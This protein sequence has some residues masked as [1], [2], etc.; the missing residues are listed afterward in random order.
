MRKTL[1]ALFLL[2]GTW[3]AT[4]QPRFRNQLLQQMAQATAL[5]LPDSLGAMTDDDSTWHYRGRTL[6][7]Q[8]GRAHV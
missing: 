2:A 6:R 4:A 5:A 3:Q 1:L 7:V 8:I